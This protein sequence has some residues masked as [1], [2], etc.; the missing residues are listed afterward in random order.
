MLDY[1]CEL[2]PEAAK[3]DRVRCACLSTVHGD[4][5]LAMPPSC[6]APCQV[7]AEQNWIPKP[8][9]FWQHKVGNCVEV[10]SVGLSNFA[11]D[12]Q[13]YF[14]CLWQI[15]PTLCI[16]W[17]SSP[18]FRPNF[19]TSISALVHHSSLSVQYLKPRKWKGAWPD[20]AIHVK[21]CGLSGGAREHYVTGRCPEVIA[22]IDH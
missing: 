15:M 12:C 8:G 16:A 19:I 11:L 10:Y 17:E 22:H 14:E 13:L 21:F 20:E 4:L 6:Q 9:G 2:Y 18:D 3:M 5:W 1:E 7:A